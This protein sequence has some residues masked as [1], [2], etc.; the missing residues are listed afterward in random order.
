MLLRRDDRFHRGRSS[1]SGRGAVVVGRR[2]ILLSRDD[3]L[4]STIGR[5]LSNGDRIARY[6][7]AELADW[8]A[9]EVAAV[10]LDSQPNARRLGYKQVRDRYH[11]PLIMLLDMDERRPNLPPDAACQF[12]HHPFKVADLSRLLD[13]PAA[14]LGPL[15]A[16]VIAAWSRHA[17]V[18]PPAVAVWPGRSDQLAAWRPSQPRRTRVWAAASIVALVGL[19]LV[20]GLSGRGSCA[21]ECTKVG[22]AIAGAA[23]TETPLT[24]TPA[25][26]S[27][28][29]GGSQPPGSSAA[30]SQPPTPT[31]GS[32]FPVVTGVGGLIQSTSPITGS[33]TTPTSGPAA[34][35]GVDPPPTTGPPATG[36]RPTA[37]H[38]PATGHHP[39]AD[40]GP[41][42]RRTAHHGAADHRAHDHSPAHDR[43]THHGPADRRAPDHRAAHHAARDH[44]AAHNRRDDGGPHDL[45]GPGS[46]TTRSAIPRRP[47]PSPHRLNA[48]PPGRPGHGPGG[49]L[50]RDVGR[51]MT[52]GGGKGSADLHG[53]RA[54]T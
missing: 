53:Q 7:S 12:L 32:A 31:S 3:G 16:A 44:R 24:S 11:G 43:P 9:P 36:D 41:A 23:E 37:E 17:T 18:E 42:D 2:V 35:P 14:G 28:R 49:L 38:H 48:T 4:A 39:A 27:A 22:G 51:D 5:L 10:I 13:A 20:A 50:R 19:L 26:G 47:A 15:Q 52:I 1:R 33:D 45:T 29:G 8:S 54:R 30:S 40:H 46:P 21:S 34:V 6:P 25:A